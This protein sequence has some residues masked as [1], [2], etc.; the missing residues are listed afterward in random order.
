LYFPRA[1]NYGHA[2]VLFRSIDAFISLS[3]FLD[4]FRSPPLE[5]SNIYEWTSF[6]CDWKSFTAKE[7]RPENCASEPFPDC[8][9]LASP[10]SPALLSTPRLH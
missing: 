3:S 5:P 4:A 1:K 8:L 7:C 2:A 10:L 6:G 9:F